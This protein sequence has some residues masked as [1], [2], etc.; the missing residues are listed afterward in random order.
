MNKSGKD[1][2]I[3]RPFRS[4]KS[5]DPPFREKN[6]YRDSLLENNEC[7]SRGITPIT[8]FHIYLPLERL[9]SFCARISAD[10]RGGLIFS[11]DFHIEHPRHKKCGHVSREIVEDLHMPIFEIKSMHTLIG[12]KKSVVKSIARARPKVFLYY[13][14]I[15]LFFHSKIFLRVAYSYQYVLVSLGR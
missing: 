14:M 1:T 9:D 4:G 5:D 10:R 13:N 8:V 12:L 3:S 11:H 2:G 6:P 15:R 7:I